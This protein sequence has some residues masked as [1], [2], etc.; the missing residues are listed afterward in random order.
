MEEKGNWQQLHQTWELLKA[1]DETSV[2]WTTLVKEL[3]QV[4]FSL[5][6]PYFID[7]DK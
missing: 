5:V 4:D 6:P 2:H 3:A 1:K 7:D